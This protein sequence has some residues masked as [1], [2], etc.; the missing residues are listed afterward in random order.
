MGRGERD[1]A[2]R[3][4]GL[5]FSRR[6]AP[7]PVY[8]AAERGPMPGS[9]VVGLTAYAAGGLLWGLGGFWDVLVQPIS[10]PLL[11]LVLLSLWPM[12]FVVAGVCLRKRLA[13]Q[14][15][16]ESGRLAAVVGTWLAFFDGQGVAVGPAWTGV[17]PRADR[18]ARGSLSR[19][20][21]GAGP[22]VLAEVL[23]TG[24]PAVWSWAG[25][26]GQLPVR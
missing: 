12:V 13:W 22:A 23:P 2:T 25:P 15:A 9:V 17:E 10:Y 6:E 8:P 18:P 3:E 24:L 7:R 1:S 5:P 20:C 26:C 16:R 11:C 4:A 19:I 14:F 21:L